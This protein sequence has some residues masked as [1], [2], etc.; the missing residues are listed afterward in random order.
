MTGQDKFRV[1]QDLRLLLLL[2]QVRKEVFFQTCH[3]EQVLA[4]KIGCNL[5]NIALIKISLL[6]QPS[7][8]RSLVITGLQNR[9]EM[10]FSPLS[11]P[12]TKINIVASIQV[13][14]LQ[15][16]K[17]NQLQ[18]MIHAHKSSFIAT[19]TFSALYRRHRRC[20]AGEQQ[21]STARAVVIYSR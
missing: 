8:S 6:D 1:S 4:N 11:F 5:L 12:A 16:Q 15:E 18:A 14:Q 7:L 20:T 17:K 10:I 13:T 2:W 9:M 3:S 21:S 19:L